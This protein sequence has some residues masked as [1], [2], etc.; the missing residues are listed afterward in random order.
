MAAAS[1]STK[2]FV[3]TDGRLL[4]QLRHRWKDVIEVPIS[5]SDRAAG[6]TKLTVAE[7]LRY[8]R[9]LARLY[10]FALFGRKI[11]AP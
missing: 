3:F 11:D 7:Q 2:D 6:Q 9:H 5:F 1:Q 10:G 8:L 4:Y